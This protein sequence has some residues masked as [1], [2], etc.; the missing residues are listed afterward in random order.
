MHNAIDIVVNLFTPQEVQAG[1]TGFD[2]NVWLAAPRCD[3]WRQLMHV[4]ARAADRDFDLSLASRSYGIEHGDVVLQGA[5]S[6]L[7]DHPQIQTACLGS[8]TRGKAPPG[9]ASCA[10]ASPSRSASTSAAIPPTSNLP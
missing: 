9:H 5:V 1:Q 8:A 4:R 10:P 7:M 6:E 3:L 2:A